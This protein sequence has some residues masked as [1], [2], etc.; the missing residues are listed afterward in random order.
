MRFK[1][2]ENEDNNGKRSCKNTELQ[3][4]RNTFVKLSRNK[5]Y[6]YTQQTKLQL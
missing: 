4:T 2:K 5:I 6:L 3:N 1:Y